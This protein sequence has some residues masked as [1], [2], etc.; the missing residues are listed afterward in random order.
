MLT[1]PLVPLRSQSVPVTAAPRPPP[2][3]RPADTAWMPRPGRW[4]GMD[5]ASTPY[6]LVRAVPEWRE[7]ALAP[8]R[9]LG[10]RGKQALAQSLTHA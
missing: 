7:P 3:V 8:M 2:R 4:N 5:A 6:G 10:D 1:V 9:R